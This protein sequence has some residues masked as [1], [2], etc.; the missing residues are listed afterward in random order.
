MNFN[1]LAESRRSIR[2]FT[3]KDV[4][5]NIIVELLKA[6]QSAPSAGNCQPWHFYVIKDKPMTEQIAKAC[7]Q[8]WMT[9]APVL[10]VVCADIQKTIGR[11]GDRGRHLYC[12]QDTAAAIQNILLCAKSLGIGTCWCG[13]FNEST[14]SEILNLQEDMRPVAIIPTGYYENESAMPQRRPIEEI[15]TFIYGKDEKKS[16]KAEEK[17]HI[18]AIEHCN[19]GKAI[20]NDVNLA[21]STFNNIN[22]NKVKFSDINMSEATF[23][24]LNLNNAK[25]GCVDMNNVEFENPSL[26]GS[27]FINCDLSGVEINNCKID[28]LKI[29]GVDISKLLENK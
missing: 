27:K 2:R 20:F 10:F 8:N 17:E 3:E 7:N 16:I 18:I 11:Y 26:N 29:N 15:A 9:T 14:V 28:E 21:E 23:G 24:G 22:M 13:A 6:A 4:P 5:D 12:L 25:F 1:E 19:M